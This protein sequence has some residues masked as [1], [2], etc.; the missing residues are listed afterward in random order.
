MSVLREMRWRLAVVE[1]SRKIQPC[2]PTPAA[3]PPSGPDWIHEIK[4]DGYRM[5]VRRDAA[6]TRLITRGGY[7]WSD[8]YP[9]IS[10]AASALKARS[11]LIDGEAVACDTDGLAEFQRLRRSTDDRN[12]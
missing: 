10:T 9:L 5:M 2:L 6:G 3:Q 8:R 4:H 1:A 7:N 12:V 11:F